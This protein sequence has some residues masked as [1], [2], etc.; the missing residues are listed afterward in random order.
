MLLNVILVLKQI[1]ANKRSPTWE[2]DGRSAGQEIPCRLRK[3][4]A[5]NWFL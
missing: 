3:P 4:R 2:A 5:H 1:L